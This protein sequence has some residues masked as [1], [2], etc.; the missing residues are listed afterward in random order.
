MNTLEIPRNRRSVVEPRRPCPP[1]PSAVLVLLVACCLAP[2]ASAQELVW[3]RG[4][5]GNSGASSVLDDSSGVAVDPAGNSYVTGSFG[6]VGTFGAG[7]P[8]ETMLS[9]AGDADVF[10]AKFDPTG[11]LLWATRA[12]GPDYDVALD[13][14]IDAAGNSYVTGLFQASATFGPGE[15]NETVLV[16][17]GAGDVFVASYDPAGALRW[18][19]RAG[20][21][22]VQSDVGRK[23]VLDATGDCLVSG[24]F[25]DA[26]TF[27]DG[28]PGET[29]LVST[30]RSDVF[31]ARF[32]PS[33]ELDHVSQAGGPEIDLG[34][35]LAVD[36]TGN[37]YVTGG[38]GP[39]TPGVVSTM[40]LG[41]G[42]PNETTLVSASAQDAFVAKYDPSGWLVWARQ[43][44]GT[45]RFDRGSDIG[46][47][48]DGAVRVV[49]VF[50]ESPTFGP[51]EP[52]QT[53]LSSAGAMD[54]WLAG[55]DAGSGLLDWVKAAG[56]PGQEFPD[57]FAI[58]P[59][60]NCH[61]TGIHQ[62]SAT[63]GPGEPNET[64]LTTVGGPDAFVAKYDPQGALIRVRSDGGPARD[65]GRGIGLDAD[66]DI[67]VTGRFSTGIT[68][69]LGEPNETTLAGSGTH[70]VYVARYRQPDSDGD[71]LNDCEETFFGTDPNDPDTDGDGLLDGTEVDIAQGSGCPDPLDPDSDAD[72]LL[73]GDEVAIGTSPCNIDSDGDG[74]PDPFDPEPTIPDTSSGP[75]EETARALAAFLG[76]LDPALVDA[77]NANAA[78]ARLNVLAN[79][80]QHAANKI[81]QGNTGAA[82]VLLANLRDRIDGDPT[83]PDWLLPSA[84]RDLVLVAVESLIALL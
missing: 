69:G 82:A 48:P 61:V 14:T 49:G 19:K 4:L 63:F 11:A 50:Q 20:G 41:L 36:A 74:L 2:G 1:V 27:G 23:I 51:G 39:P 60:G 80:A 59:Y 32:T 52:G 8:N 30:G 55:F 12:G 54:V 10:V 37:T 65:V 24:D 56:G 34:L 81:A 43:A 28:E 42:E 76:S 22:S 26:A 7:E 25:W 79:H 84:E 68:L 38:F 16:S 73:D 13:I 70:D 58:D 40:T 33:G 15:G 6:E 31:V 18:A 17:A 29:V 5:G 71:G 35:A 46:I 72:S 78:V 44:G 62:S 45:G 57:G 3:A 77:P 75:L 66:G 53:T 67:Y 21:G 83:P 47:A 9:S 64:T